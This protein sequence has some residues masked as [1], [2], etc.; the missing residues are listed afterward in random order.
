MKTNLIECKAC[1]QKIAT[2][3]RIC[4]KCGKT[5][6]SPE[7]IAIAIILGLFL[8]FLLFGGACS[9][10]FDA[11]RSVNKAERDLKINSWP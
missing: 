6:S 3:A 8:S 5:R 11:R 7:G 1:G 9:M 10:L 2:S 4:P